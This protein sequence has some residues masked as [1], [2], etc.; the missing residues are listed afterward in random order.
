MQIPKYISHPLLLL[1]GGLVMALLIWVAVPT[2]ED[3]HKAAEKDLKPVEA[4]SISQFVEVQSVDDQG[5]LEFPG[6][7]S[8]A[9][10]FSARCIDDAWFSKVNKRQINNMRKFFTG[11]W[12]AKEAYAQKQ[13]ALPLKL[14][15]ASCFS[16]NELDHSQKKLC[17][18]VIAP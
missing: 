10:K 5:C 7:G 4:M 15:D 8:G 13:L 17:P 11:K 18:M 6:T 3:V 1:S 16:S 12:V 2:A 9:R 14:W